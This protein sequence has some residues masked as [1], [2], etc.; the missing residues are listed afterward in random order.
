M[1]N[2]K[3][4]ELAKEHCDHTVNL[5][6]GTENYDLEISETI[7]RE[8]NEK[9]GKSGPIK[10]LYGKIHNSRVDLY[11]SRD[12]AYMGILCALTGRNEE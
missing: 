8:I 5:D 6:D 4:M 11:S 7:Y 10:E 3:L 12:N 2:R 1:K 9:I